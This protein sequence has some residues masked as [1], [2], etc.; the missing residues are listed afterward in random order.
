MQGAC[1]Q[2]RAF[3]GFHPCGTCGPSNPLPNGIKAIRDR[4]KILYRIDQ[5]NRGEA[6]AEDPA[7]TLPRRTAKA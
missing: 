1:F 7:P 5:A 3:T 2:H 4:E 6:P